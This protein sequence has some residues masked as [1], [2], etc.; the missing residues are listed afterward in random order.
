[1]ENPQTQDI[2]PIISH[3]MRTSLTTMKWILKML[4]DGDTENLPMNKKRS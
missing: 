2:L 4:I 1:M 3:Q